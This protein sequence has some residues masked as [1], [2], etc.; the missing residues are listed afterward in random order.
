MRTLS[1]RSKI[2]IKNKWG[3]SIE[4]TG[5]YLGL[6]LF[7]FNSKLCSIVATFH[8]RVDHEQAERLIP[9]LDRLL[10]QS[11]K[12]VRD[13]DLIAVDIGPGSF[14][15]VRIGVTVARTISQGFNLPLIGVSSLESMAWQMTRQFSRAWVAVLIPALPNEIYFAVYALK[16][17]SHKISIEEVMP[18]IWGS[19]NMAKSELS[20]LANKCPSPIP[21][22]VVS[23]EWRDDISTLFPSHLPI[24]MWPTP[25]S[26]KSDYIGW[27]GV[28]KY[29]L[30]KK[31]NWSFS[32]TNPLYLQPSWAE[33]KKKSR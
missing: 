23:S 12:R 29:H 15:G 27:A 6:S 10:N 20:R 5:A 25:I 7:K 14:T 16:D 26:P 30:N 33:R 9:S 22:L 2:S 11:K 19:I 24:R 13:L 3:L 4:T 18:P 1:R 31:Q 17:R 32:H 21:F 28:N 8:E